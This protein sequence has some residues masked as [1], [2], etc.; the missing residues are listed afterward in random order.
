MG[1]RP[2]LFGD[3]FGRNLCGQA[4]PEQAAHGRYGLQLLCSEYAFD[5]CRIGRAAGV[6]QFAFV[7]AAG[8]QQRIDSGLRRAGDVGLQA[9]ADGEPLRARNVAAGELAQAF[10]D[11]GV[12]GA[13]GF[14]R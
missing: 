14:P 2:S 8:D 5:L 11:E 1:H 10:G 4:L 6:G 7:D 12:T 13:C 9:V 3:E